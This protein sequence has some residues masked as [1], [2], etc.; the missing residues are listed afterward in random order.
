MSRDAGNRRS[1]RRA[2]SEP[3]RLLSRGRSGSDGRTTRRGTS[4]RRRS[5]RR[6]AT[7]RT[8]AATGR[9]RRGSGGSRSARR[10]AAR[11]TGGRELTLDELVE[12]APVP[13][14]ERDP[15]LAEAVRGLVA[16]AAARRL[17]P[18]LRG[19]PVRRD[20]IPA[21]HQRGHRRG[22]A[23]AS[24]CRAARATS[25]QGGSAM[26]EIARLE[27]ALARVRAPRRTTARTGT[28]CCG[29]RGERVRPRVVLGDDWRSLLAAA[30]VAASS[31]GGLP[32]RARNS[33][34]R[35]R[36]PARRVRPSGPMPTGAIRWRRTD[37]GLVERSQR[38]EGR[39]SR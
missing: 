11:A 5:R 27:A 31:V 7:G 39:R 13:R 34:D 37:A 19:S 30:V 25:R 35:R 15:E 36:S 14:A 28:T 20:R 29:E 9:S 4:C 16:A 12:A 38:A 21:R 33:R 22:D 26:S 1:D 3:L 18:L 32:S 10:C 2:L 6:S 23:L 17:P 24:A 8:T